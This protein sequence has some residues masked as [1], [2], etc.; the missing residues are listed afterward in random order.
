MNKTRVLGIFSAAMFGLFGVNSA[1]AALF[2]ASCASTPG[3]VIN[4][5]IDPVACAAG[6]GGNG[7]QAEFDSVIAWLGGQGYDID[8]WN[9]IGKYD[10][11]GGAEG[12]NFEDFALTVTPGN[13]TWSYSFSVTSEKYA[14]Y[15][16]DFVLFIKQGNAEDFA[17]YWQQVTLD[18]EG[19]YNSF[20]VNG[21]NDYSHVSGFV[22]IG[23]K[24]EVPEPTT[25]ALLGLGLVGFGVARR[26]MAT[27]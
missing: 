5:N 12:Q 25:L 6:D 3:A 10:K 15:D 23:E 24:T 18:I 4:P 19:F 27:R 7:A 8:G 13:Q 11:N 20:N 26:R 21:G 14:G 17:Y 16:I 22:R 2:D 1:S 9:S